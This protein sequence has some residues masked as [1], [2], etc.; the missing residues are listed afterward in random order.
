MMQLKQNS[1]DA[2]RTMY[3][4]IRMKCGGNLG[5]GGLFAGMK[6]GPCCLLEQGQRM[7]GAIYRDEVLK[8][9]GFPFY[10]RTFRDKKGALWMDDNA[11]IILCKAIKRYQNEVGMYRIW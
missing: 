3:F 6:K 5:E 2:S 7:N 4:Q 10:E 9:L 1:I 8:P 11:N